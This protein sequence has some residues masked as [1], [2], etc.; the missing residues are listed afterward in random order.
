MVVGGSIP[1][2]DTRNKEKLKMNSKN[3]QDKVLVGIVHEFVED[4]A[5]VD[6][7]FQGVIERRVMS[8]NYLV[9]S[10]VKYEGQAFEVRRR[11]VEQTDG[12]F[13]MQIL[14]CPLPLVEIGEYETVR[15]QEVV[16]KALQK[17]SKRVN[18]TL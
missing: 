11:K 18:K 7:I 17:R 6:L 2:W 8:R 14:I 13:V 10:G 3:K 15:P 1:P 5:F 12:S 4:D 9:E 16:E